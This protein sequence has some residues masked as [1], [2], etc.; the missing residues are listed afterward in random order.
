MTVMQTRDASDPSVTDAGG[1]SPV[2][3][4]GGTMSPVSHAGTMDKQQ[5]Q[6][7]QMFVQAPNVP[8]PER[9]PV[10]ASFPHMLHMGDAQSA[11][12]PADGHPIVQ[13]RLQAMPPPPGYD[14][15]GA[16]DHGQQQVQPQQ[17]G[18]AVLQSP[19]EYLL[20]HTQ[21]ELGMARAAPY[22][23]ADPYFGGIVAAT[24]G[25]QAVIHPH[26][27]G[28][29]QA[30]MPLPSEMME[31]E[32]VYVN[33][34]QYHGILRRRQSRAKAESENKLIKARKPYLHESRHQH[35]LRRARGCGGRFLN[36]KAKS[37][38]GK[39]QR[40][41]SRSSSEAQ[42]SQRDPHRSPRGQG[43]LMNSVHDS[44]VLT[45]S[46]LVQL[47]GGYHGIL[48]NGG[49]QGMA[50]TLSPSGYHHQSQIYASAFHP[51]A[52]GDPDG[53]QNG[54]MVSSGSQQTVVATQ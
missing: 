45:S 20:P 27:L 18:A 1:V 29:Q 13:S 24:Y 10:L 31:E 54:S 30:R 17:S 19:A 42:S 23:Y 32:P 51:L 5:Q 14:T 3:W 12:P 8:I 7:Q 25:A 52:T 2:A 4:V 39:T 36:T 46:G 40:D 9:T 22:P 6:Q 15:S 44:G 28:I 33:A 38:E 35:A 48:P 34:K 26:V 41:D 37:D 11:Q 53:G 21:L 50:S 16:E 49:H 47:A 43:G